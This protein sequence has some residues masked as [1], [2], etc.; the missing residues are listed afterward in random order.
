MIKFTLSRRAFFGLVDTSKT[1]EIPTTLDE[2]PSDKL[3]QVFQ[4][5]TQFPNRTDA[6]L[7]ILPILTGVHRRQLRLLTD[8]DLAALIQKIEFLK[9]EPN[10]TILKTVK[11][12]GRTYKNP[13]KD[14]RLGT[15]FEFATAE[16]LFLEFQKG[17]PMALYRLFVT[18][19]A[20]I[21]K[22]IRQSLNDRQQVEAIADQLKENGIDEGYLVGAVLYFTAARES[23]LSKYG[24]FVFSEE[25]ETDAI[26]EKVAANFPNFGWWSVARGVAS[27]GVFG[28]Y[29]SVLK[30]NAHRI[31]MHL[32]EE[33]KHQKIEKAHLDQIQKDAK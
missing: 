5:L 1:Y 6:L 11:I 15:F 28:D 18:L 27:T 10:D 3:A 26:A 20:P 22:N 29:D 4:K 7:Q 16:T 25:G 14:F 21:S 19:Y 13:Q 2:I 9:V 33:Q 32:V 8:L 31:F 17:D 23:L 30:T 12:G 24:K